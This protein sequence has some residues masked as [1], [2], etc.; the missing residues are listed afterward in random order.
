MD[1]NAPVSLVTASYS[2]RDHAVEDFNAVWSARNEGE[3]HHTAIATLT[4]DADGSFH[5][6]RNDHTAKYLVWGGALLGGAL[7]VVEPSVGIE[8]LSRVGVSGAGA[9]V[10]HLRRNADPAALARA[11]DVLEHGQWSLVVLVVNRR[12]AATMMLLEHAAELSSIEMLW[13][14]LEEELCQDFARPLSGAVLVAM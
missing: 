8:M 9:I 6:D 1:V 2:T 3:F 4:K 10:G 12:S 14:D 7:F 11:A 13:G 5:V